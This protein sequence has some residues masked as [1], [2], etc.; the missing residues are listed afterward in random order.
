M[1]LRIFLF[2]F[3]QLSSSIFHEVSSH[4]NELWSLI[5]W[6]PLLCNTSLTSF[7]IWVH[8]H[9]TRLLT[10]KTK[11]QCSLSKSILILLPIHPCHTIPQPCSCSYS[12]VH[13]TVLLFHKIHLSWPSPYWN[14]HCSSP[15][16]FLPWPLIS[17][18]PHHIPTWR[19][20]EM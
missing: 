2:S 17:R 1:N 16:P 3:Y 19:K 20:I 9:N 10:I 13:I 5:L 18:L 6:V 14:Q 4:Q 12:S 8:I 15:P 11:N 7:I